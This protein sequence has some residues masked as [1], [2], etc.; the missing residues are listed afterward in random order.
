MLR[1]AV[2]VGVMVVGVGMVGLVLLRVGM[3]DPF[4]SKPQGDRPAGTPPTASKPKSDG[5]ASDR[6]GPDP[7]AFD[8]D[9]AMGYLNDDCKIGARISGTDG[10]KQQQDL[11]KKHFEALG[12][13]RDLAALHGPTDQR[14][15]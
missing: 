15:P 1:F 4:A 10:M 6:A 3:A 8:A 13:H 9:R 2:G 14:G 12:A 7:L 11:L 5:F